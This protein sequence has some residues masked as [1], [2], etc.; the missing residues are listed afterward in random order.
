MEVSEEHLREDE[1]RNYIGL[2]ST[3]LT[4]RSCGICLSDTF[5]MKFYTSTERTK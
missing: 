2:E 1:N 5:L 3:L 4:T